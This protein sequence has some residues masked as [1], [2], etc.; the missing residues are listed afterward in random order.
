VHQQQLLP[1]VLR[2]IHSRWELERGEFAFGLIHLEGILESLPERQL[3]VF[4][5]VVKQ[6]RDLGRMG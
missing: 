1:G 2:W 6:R 5:A 3:A 4:T